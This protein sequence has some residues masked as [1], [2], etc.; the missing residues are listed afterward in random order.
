[1]HEAL[2][3]FGG[4]IIP[5]WNG[6]AVAHQSSGEDVCAAAAAATAAAASTAAGTP[7]GAVRVFFP[8]CGKS[9][10]MAVLAR[11]PSVS[12]VVGVDGIRAAL[13][14]F[15]AEHPDL[16]I[17][18]EEPA[19]QPQQPDKA[20]YDRLIGDNIMLLK[21]DFFEVDENA[22]DGRFDAVF[23]RGSL[24]AIEPSLRRDYV[25]VMRGL[26]KPGGKML[27][28]VVERTS[29]TEEDLTA[30]PPF[31]VPEAE[32]R[33]LYES[34]DWVQSVTL[35]ESDGEKERNADRDMRSLFFLVET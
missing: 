22:V 15:S 35:L 10:D 33:S 8:L 17:R 3:R 11:H 4:L 7:G 12:Q 30:G 24:V 5:G 20:K 1:V 2:A 26:V 13:D 23:D 16:A 31:S 28:V 19:L 9:V 14:D 21:G 6:E 27:L 18:D 32:V 25:N 34:Q 29:G